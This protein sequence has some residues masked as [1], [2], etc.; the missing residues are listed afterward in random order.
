MR[1]TTVGAETQGGVARRFCQRD[2]GGS[3]IDSKMVSI[4][5]GLRQFTIGEQ[6]RWIVCYSL[7]Q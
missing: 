2:T 5:V 7:I 6:E 1:L 3:P 4:G